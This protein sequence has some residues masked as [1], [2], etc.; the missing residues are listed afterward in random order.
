M[1]PIVAHVTTEKGWRGG[2]N[3]IRL[4]IE[5]STKA[6]WQTL[7]ICPPDS[8][9]SKWAKANAIGCIDW[10]AANDI[11]LIAAWRLAQ[12]LR[13]KSISLV[14]THS[15]R[16]HTMGV[17]AKYF[18]APSQLIVYRR[19]N[20]PLTRGIANRWKFHNAAIRCFVAISSAI[21]HSL[22]EFGIA[23][24][25]VHTIKSSIDPERIQK[26]DRTSC[27]TEITQNLGIPSTSCLIGFA[28][29]VETSKGADVLIHA[30]MQLKN[31]ENCHLLMA[32]E[33]PLIE[34]LKAELKSQPLEQRVHFL[35]FLQDT[36]P[37]MKALDIFCLPS[38]EEGL[39]TVL[40]EAIA[41]EV[42]CVGS[43]VGGIPEL[44]KHDK[45]GFL[46]SPG[47][48]DE[49]HLCLEKAASDLSFRANA[50]ALSQ[51]ILKD[52]HVETMVDKTI[53]LFQSLVSTN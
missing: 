53:Q 20:F 40:L 33:G 10:H 14:A 11:D 24:K 6:G 46:F 25:R 50:V 52:H 7:L 41:A 42:F 44:I 48:S 30:F 13:K 32:G 17:L 8:A 39:G 19:T 45:T 1:A 51:D 36:A 47:S 35:G 3:Q 16:A 18:G 43:R 12:L 37:F 28:G 2:E 29:R 5:G 38:L 9:I 49:L 4:L 27:R 23:S 31:A 22:Q 15:A 26:L 21:A 34:Q